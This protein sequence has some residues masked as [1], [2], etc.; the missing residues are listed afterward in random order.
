MIPAIYYYCTPRPYRR[1]LIIVQWYINDKMHEFMQGE[2]T[3]ILGTEKFVQM[4]VFS[5][6]GCLLFISS[7]TVNRPPPPAQ[8]CGPSDVLRLYRIS[9]T[10]SDVCRQLTY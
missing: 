3:R 7:Y 2:A 4:F 8:V 10:T 9:S 6:A 5:E 1:R